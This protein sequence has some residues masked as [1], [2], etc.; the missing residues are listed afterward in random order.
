MYAFDDIDNNIYNPG[1]S[2]ITT[3]SDL[4]GFDSNGEM[5]Q[6]DSY[7]DTARNK[8]G[9]REDINPYWKAYNYA[10]G[11]KN[12][13]FWLSKALDWEAN[14]DAENRARSREDYLINQARERELADRAHS[15]E[16]DSPIEQVKR[17]RAAG[18]NPNLSDS[19]SAGSTQDLDTPVGESGGTFAG[20]QHG[21]TVDDPSDDVFTSYVMPALSTV[22]SF[23]PAVGSAVSAGLNV[24][25]NELSRAN[26]Q[27]AVENN[28][29]AATAQYNS[30]AESDL[31]YLAQAAKHLSLQTDDSGN[32]LPLTRERF[33]SF[34][35][36]T[37]RQWT[38]DRSRLIDSYLSNTDLQ[39][40]AASKLEERNETVAKSK[41]GSLDFYDKYAEHIYKA[42]M[43]CIQAQEY[44]TEVQELVAQ[45]LAANPQYA[46]DLAAIE[47]GTASQSASGIA[48]DIEN[49]RASVASDNSVSEMQL[50]NDTVN[51][52]RDVYKRLTEEADSRIADIDKMISRLTSP[53]GTIPTDRYSEYMALRAAKSSLIIQTYDSLDS[54]SDNLNNVYRVFSSTAVLT[55][56]NTIDNTSPTANSSLRHH[57]I[58]WSPGTPAT[59]TVKDISSKI[60][61]LATKLIP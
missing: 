23:I 5:V 32:S 46:Q 17:L 8:Y 13:K 37:N 20:S 24:V 53:D 27:A 14:Y 1:G 3:G 15:E 6:P 39:T 52:I 12:K 61:N 29:L 58:M 55:T 9:I 7:N 21:G 28:T 45:S 2:D 30:N 51:Q 10:S 40:Y 35:D 47:A 22:A 4:T 25:N 43:Y 42:R 19:V 41:F 44:T 31:S 48:A 60:S 36:G 56:P 11:K 16:Y 50:R 34:L 49:N 26:Q 38:V 57:Y 18:I 59:D 54:M 33:Q